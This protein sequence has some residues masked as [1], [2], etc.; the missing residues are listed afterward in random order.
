MPRAMH[1]TIQQEGCHQGT[2]GRST[3]YG[4]INY[5]VK[6]LVLEKFGQQAWFVRPRLLLYLILLLQML[7]R[8]VYI[9]G[10]PNT[11]TNCASRG[12]AA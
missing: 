5:S 9:F 2:S 6:T 10:A 1:S 7:K 8:S 11:C 12:T 3:M 4:I